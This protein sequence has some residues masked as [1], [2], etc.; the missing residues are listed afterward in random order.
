[1]VIIRTNSCVFFVYV[2]EHICVCMDF[3]KLPEMHS[4]NLVYMYY[5]IFVVYVFVFC[6]TFLL[7][8][9]FSF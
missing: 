4:I 5:I 7:L 8:T 6:D 2:C 9:I 1:M 3:L